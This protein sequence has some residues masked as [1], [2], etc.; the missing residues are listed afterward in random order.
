MGNFLRSRVDVV[1]SEMSNAQ[2]D[3]MQILSI[4]ETSRLRIDR[5]S[6]DS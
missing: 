5:W 2:L 3:A 1:E 4:D 6:A